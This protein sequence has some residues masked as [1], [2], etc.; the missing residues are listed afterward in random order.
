MLQVFETRTGRELWKTERGSLSRLS[1]PHG[2]LVAQQQPAG[3]LPGSLLTVLRAE[4][5]SQLSQFSLD[6][7]L[8]LFTDD[9]VAYAAPKLPSPAQAWVAAVATTGG[10]REL[11]RADGVHAHTLALD[12]GQ[13]YYAGVRQDP[14][15]RATPAGLA[16]VGALD[17][18]TGTKLWTWRSPHTTAELLQVWGTRTPAMLLDSAKK[19]WTTITDALTDS[20]QRKS[21]LLRELHGGHWRHPYT[22][23]ASMNALWLEARDGLV[24]VGTWLGL[25]ALDGKDGT[26]R[27]LGVPDLDLSFI[28]PALPP[29]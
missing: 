27:W 19:S 29:P 10:G 22:L 1:L 13:L 16:E 4:D 2:K 3:G 11:W 12:G 28:T 17:V 18:H 26:L 14:R 20:R 5:G 25:L 15:V 6:G 23:H 21:R 24:F 8:H 7:R 9:G